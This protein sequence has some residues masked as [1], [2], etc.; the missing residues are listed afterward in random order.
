MP[1]VLEEPKKRNLPRKY[2]S[3]TETERWETT[4]KTKKRRGGEWK[5]ERFH[6]SSS[7]SKRRKMGDNRFKALAEPE[8]KGGNGQAR[9]QRGS[10]KESRNVTENIKDLTSHKKAREKGRQEKQR[11]PSPKHRL[12]TT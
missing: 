9:T 4:K 2:S 7:P 12:E 5:G 3:G 10:S 1:S 8:E 6:Q 11:T